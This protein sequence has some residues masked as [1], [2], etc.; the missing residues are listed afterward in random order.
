MKRNPSRLDRRFLAFRKCRSQKNPKTLTK[1]VPIKQTQSLLTIIPC[2]FSCLLS[3][4][5]FHEML[6]L[7]GVCKHVRTLVEPN[8][9]RFPVEAF[10][11]IDGHFWD[12]FVEKLPDTFRGVV[13]RCAWLTD[14]DVGK[15]YMKIFSAIENTTFVSEM[16]GDEVFDINMKLALDNKHATVRSGVR[17][18]K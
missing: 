16:L 10:V 9:Y 7:S 12:A 2:V 8:F 13:P 3:F 1:N 17:V 6:R 15:F 18:A 5:T 11:C 4:L 14:E